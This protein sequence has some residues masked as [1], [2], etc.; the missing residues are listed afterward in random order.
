MYWKKKT[1]RRFTWILQSQ[2]LDAVHVEDS[3][4]TLYLQPEKKWEKDKNMEERD[5]EDGRME[6]MIDR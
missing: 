3:C 2:S 4:H 1:W 6:R 5:E